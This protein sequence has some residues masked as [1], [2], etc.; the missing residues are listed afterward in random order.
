MQ[1]LTRKSEAVYG[2]DV[3]SSAVYSSYTQKVYQCNNKLLV[4]QD[5][6]VKHH[7]HVNYG[8]ENSSYYMTSTCDCQ[9]NDQGFA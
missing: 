2:N 9:R 4:S 8:K 6:Y 7:G 5:G 3:M 1:A